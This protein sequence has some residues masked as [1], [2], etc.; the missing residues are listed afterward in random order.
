MSSAVS[1]SQHDGN[2]GCYPAS[3]DAAELFPNDLNG[4]ELL[5]FMLNKYFYQQK[6]RDGGN[7]FK[8]IKYLYFVSSHLET[9]FIMCQLPL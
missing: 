6:G 1:F 3:T 9:V 4:T 8:E 2:T 7:Q 5:S